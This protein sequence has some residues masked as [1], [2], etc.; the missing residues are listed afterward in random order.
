MS[1]TSNYSQ[2]RFRPPK[3]YRGSGRLL[4]PWANLNVLILILIFLTSLSLSA[5]TLTATLDREIVPLGE[6][7]ALTLTFENAR[8][9]GAPNLPP[10]PNVIV[11]SVGQSTEVTIVNGQQTARQIYAYTLQPNA[12]GDVTIPTISVLA[13]GQLL[14]SQPLKLK[15]VQGPGANQPAAIPQ[16]AFLKLMVSKTQVYLGEP[17]PL[18]ITLYVQEARDPN[19]PQLEGE[20]FTV[21]KIIQAPQSRTQ[22]NGQIYNLV[23]FKTYVAPARAGTL[24]LGPATMGIT[25]PKPNARRGIFGIMETDWQRITL[26]ADAQSIT[27][28]PLP[29]NNVPD[30]FNGAVGSYVLQVTAGPNNLAVGDPITVKVQVS[31]RG[32]LDAL[33]LPEQ[34]QWREFKAYPP[35]SNLEAADQH[36]LSGVKTFEQVLIPQNHEIKALPAFEFSFFDP[37]QRAYRTVTGGGM[38]LAIRATASAAPPA[39]TNALAKKDPPAQQDIFHIKTRGLAV[40]QPPLI[41][42]PWFL[43]IQA[44]PLLAWGAAA[45]GRRRRERLANNPRLR[46]RREVQQKVEQGL[47]EL[48]ALS[49]W[50]KPED[51]FALLFRLLQEQLGER[52]DLSA[53]SITEAALEEPVVRTQLREESVTT[54]HELFQLCNQARYAPER[55]ASSLGELLPQVR[56]AFTELQQIKAP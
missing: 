54:L 6:T 23:P 25:I 32:L 55:G 36:A 11:A 21:G 40:A 12:V 39:L 14:A 50:Q 27:V 2:Q 48:G 49:H 53:S 16:T 5:G 20:G 46:R 52:L 31:G 56:H 42:R 10:L 33:A 3:R 37:Q 30:H 1:H 4:C 26:K 8:P 35:T 9:Q 38:P 13:S 15:V 41:D 28:L 18:E 43:A 19:M 24:R 51:F 34:P 47:H 22:A 44:V 29:T 7:V 45:V 17:I